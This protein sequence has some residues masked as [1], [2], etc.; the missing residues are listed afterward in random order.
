M[1]IERHMANRSRVEK[2]ETQGRHQRVVTV[3]S[4]RR[5]EKNHGTRHIRIY[6]Q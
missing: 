3:G 5:R 4:S 1:K 2:A 6:E